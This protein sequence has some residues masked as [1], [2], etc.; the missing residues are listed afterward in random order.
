MWVA[1][2][3]VAVFY[4][5]YNDLNHCDEISTLGVE[6]NKQLSFRNFT[7]RQDVYTFKWLLPM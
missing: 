2:E 5:N 1:L 7:W 6:F 4:R 3:N